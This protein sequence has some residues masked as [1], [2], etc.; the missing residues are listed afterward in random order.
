[1][2]NFY[3]DKKILIT[4]HTGFKGAW[5][6]QILLNWGADIAGLSLLPET[7][8][9]LFEVLGLQKKITNYFYDIRDYSLVRKVVLKERPEI[10]FH[11]AAQ[12]LVRESYDD[13]IKTF[14]TNTMGTVHILHAIREAG[15]VKSAVIITTDKVYKNAGQNRPQKEADPLGGHD[16]YSA[17]KA[18][19]EMVIESY[20]KSFF[21][22][23]DFRKNHNTLIASARAGNVIGG[24]DWARDRLIPDFIR[25][26][27]EKKNKLTIRKPK[28]IRPWQYVLDPLSGYLILAKR[29]HAGEKKLS[30]AWNFGP[31]K[32][33]FVSVEEI[34]KK[35]SIMLGEADY[36]IRPQNDKPEADVLKLDASKAEKLLGW[37][38]K[39]NLDQS[40]EC[41]MEWY[42]GYYS[43]PGHILKLTDNQIKRFFN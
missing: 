27:C 43:D 12:A 36:K 8:P 11:L 29:L 26:A 39:Y 9:S 41:A 32:R 7:E 30:S 37:T 40:L 16:P 6:T 10:V 25:S 2:K 23:A 13:P 17:S 4:G 1:M 31:P 20:A 38:P 14:A 15:C 33:S 18:A 22:P 3:R 19:A 28:A 34:M 5:L 24:G 42:K 35:L 21:N